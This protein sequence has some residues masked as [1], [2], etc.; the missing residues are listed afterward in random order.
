MH[1]DLPP[2]LPLTA[3]DTGEFPTKDVPLR[4]DVHELGSLLGEMLAE[5]GGDRLYERVEAS[6]Q[7]ARRRRTGDELAGEELAGLLGNLSP[8]DA[9]E[10]VRAFSAW[11]RLVN[12]A[13]QVHRLRRRRAW[14]FSA[15]KPQPAGL[16]DVLQ[17][18]AARGVP[19]DAVREQIAALQLVPVFTAHPTEAVRRT[20]LTKQQRIA[21]VLVSRMERERLTAGEADSVRDTIRNE[22]VSAWQTDEHLPVRP[23]VADEVEH[24]LYYVSDVIFDVVPQLFEELEAAFAAAF[25]PGEELPVP[26]LRFGSWVGGDMDGNPSVGADTIRATLARHRDLALRSYRER[27]RD[28]FDQLSHSDTRVTI[29]HDVTQRLA[30]YRDAFPDASAAMA[31]RYS[32]MPYRQLLWLMLARLDATQSDDERGYHGPA[33]LLADA[34]AIADSLLSHGARD[35]GWRLVRRFLW[36]VKV[37]GFHLAQLDLRQDSEVHRDAVGRLLN[38]AEFAA[39]PADDRAAR[40]LAALNEPAGLTTAA[41]AADADT[42][43]TLDVMRAV[44][45]CRRR[46]GTE[47]IGP[48]IISMAQG[49]DDVLA[50]LLLAR[51][52]GLVDGEA[53]MVPL[54]VAPLFET[55]DDLAAGPD[56]LQRMLDNPHYRDHLTA[57]GNQQMVML[58]YSDSAKDA[59]LASARHALD[60]AQRA[61]VDVANRNGIHLTLFHGRGGSTSRGGGKIRPAVMA[62][63]A[64]SLRGRLR[65]TEQGEIIHAKYGVPGIALRTLE[66][67]TGAVLEFS[68][69]EDTAPTPDPAWQAAMAELATA[70]RA[71]WKALGHADPAFFQYF[72][73]ATPIDV[74]ERMA[75]G[76]RPPSRRQQSGIRDLR[77]IPWVFAWTQCR[78]IM[79]GWYG[80]GLGLRA[81]Q[82]S[83]GS[84]LLQEM[85][86]GWPFF[87]TLLADV[88]M[89]LAKA[90]MGIARRYA[91]LAGADGAPVFTQLQDEFQRTAERI[92]DARG[93]QRLL[94]NELALRRAIRLR[95]PYIDPMSLLQIDLL[96][97]WRAADRPDGELLDALFTTVKGIAGGMQNTG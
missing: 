73:T 40:I 44:A 12:M 85:A 48:Y 65:L 60:A 92:C 83:H 39:R 1:S 72:R 19:A 55:V 86:A 82:Q 43:R 16:V 67:M 10:V 5:L 29:S 74:I 37:F 89:V 20:L 62:Q 93:T 4:A 64:G 41:T 70:S 7:A 52:G 47:A 32:R 34:K 71:A 97:R 79:P 53:D 21:G 94:E 38:D 9:S 51:A 91:R 17:R 56:T 58:G 23:T 66:L 95:N 50:V 69:G 22:L 26:A 8:A 2:A 75:I 49:A 14:Q 90:D 96:K 63:P 81:V 42:Q 46:F 57:R 78:A 28:L 25:G 87:A 88:E 45:D 30:G 11:F 15:D 33:E 68:I 36:Q 80:V 3:G 31:A 27:V 61:L 84:T 59:G 76:S 77:A 24:V 13:E 35:G 6:R 18:L 54:D